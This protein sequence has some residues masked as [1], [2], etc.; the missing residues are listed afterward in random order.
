MFASD[1]STERNRMLTMS[2]FNW[3]GKS[4][5]SKV[6][7]SGPTSPTSKTYMFTTSSLVLWASLKSNYPSPTPWSPKW[8]T[9][10]P[11]ISSTL[12]RETFSSALKA[13]ALVCVRLALRLTSR[14]RPCHHQSLGC[15]TCLL[16][17]PNCSS[18]PSFVPL[19]YR[20]HW[21]PTKET[22]YC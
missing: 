19:G 12:W 16:P 18:L 15:H 14:N 21:Y 9:A 3:S 5:R 7:A 4:R 20:Y 22:W 8:T 11:S 17:H 10:F 6:M 1:P 13:L 2:K